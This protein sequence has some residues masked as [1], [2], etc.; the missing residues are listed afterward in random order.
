[1][2]DIFPST[3][4]DGKHQR[5]IQCQIC[6]DI[7]FF[8]AA[9][10]TFFI[11]KVSPSDF[12]GHREVNASRI[13][14]ADSFDNARGTI[15][16]WELTPKDSTWIC[17]PVRNS[18]SSEISGE[19]YYSSSEKAICCLR[20]IL[21]KNF[22]QETILPM[23]QQRSFRGERITL[24]QSHFHRVMFR[25]ILNW[26]PVCA[27]AFVYRCGFYIPLRSSYIFQ[28]LGNA[29]Y[30]TVSWPPSWFF[31]SWFFSC[32]CRGS[33]L[34]TNSSATT[35]HIAKTP[36]SGESQARQRKKFCHESFEYYGGDWVHTADWFSV[37]WL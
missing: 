25:S 16:G 23:Q 11:F 29:S 33:T 10:K 37:F 7:S 22:P 31:F 8:R 6:F 30:R 13:E 28:L 36:R 26:I 27:C 32:S 1:M 12:L 3:E 18:C 9:W 2:S 5:K 15:F 14:T 20:I 17:L 34:A 19:P 4:T 35:K 21:S 24:P